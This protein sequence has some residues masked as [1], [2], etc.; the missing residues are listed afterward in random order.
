MSAIED[1]TMQGTFGKR[2]LLEA[3][4][5]STSSSNVRVA[6]GTSCYYKLTVVVD[7]ELQNF[8]KADVREM[9]QRYHNDPVKDPLRDQEKSMSDVVGDEVQCPSRPNESDSD[10]TMRLMIDWLKRIFVEGEKWECPKKF[11]ADAILFD[12]FLDDMN[13]MHSGLTEEQYRVVVDELLLLIK[14]Q[15]TNHQE[16]GPL[17]LGM[18]RA[19]SAFDVDSLSY[20]THQLMPEEV[21][22]E[23]SF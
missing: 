16:K 4:G 15:E 5:S 9:Y 20:I 21:E 12:D 1:T 19:K 8:I 6:D 18:A 7:G 17:N 14:D 23:D 11:Y 10:R 2:A 3:S 13:M 22:G